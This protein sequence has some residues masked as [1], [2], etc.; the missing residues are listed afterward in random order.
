MLPEF[1][2]GPPPALVADDER[3]V[4]HI[5]A[6]RTQGRRAVGGGLH[7]TTHRLLFC[8]NVID[9][10][11]GGQRWSCAVS[12]ISTI[13]VQPRRFSLL[14]LFS[15][16]LVERLRLDL[17]DG[18]SELFVTSKPQQRADELRELLRLPESS[19]TMPTMRVIK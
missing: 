1:W 17:H 18:R 6:N 3:W 11:L 14:E 7:L 4:L 16:G 13:G 12:E 8:P 2:F 10:R 15:G 9:A 5:A 19:A